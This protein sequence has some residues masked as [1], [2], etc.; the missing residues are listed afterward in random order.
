MPSGDDPAVPAVP[1]EDG[2]RLV[3]VAQDQR[4]AG[5]SGRAEAVQLVE[6]DRAAGPGDQ[7]QRSPGLDRGELV[8]VAQQ[9]QHGAG[10]G[11]VGEDALQQQGA[12]HA[13][14]V[15]EDHVARP[16]AEVLADLQAP[17][18][19]V[20]V[21]QPGVQGVGAPVQ[22]LAEDLRRAGGRG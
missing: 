16:Q 22:V 11:R 19:A 17:G 15:D 2:A 6:F 20:A 21:V 5:L 13:R 8:R 9:A 14:L 18:G 3:A 1:V 4:G 12:R 10:G 7:P